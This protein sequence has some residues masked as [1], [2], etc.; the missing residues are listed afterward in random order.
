MPVPPTFQSNYN[1]L[2]NRFIFKIL[3]KQNFN[4]SFTFENEESSTHND[5]GMS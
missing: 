1:F 2:I 3:V 4:F 5:T